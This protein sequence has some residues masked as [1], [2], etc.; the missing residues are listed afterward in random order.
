MA[1]GDAADA[2]G[3][4]VLAGTEDLRDS[5]VEHNRSRDYIATH[6]TS[7]THS[8]AAITSGTLDADRLPPIPQS[9]IPDEIPISKIGSGVNAGR[10]T[11][12]V[13]TSQVIASGDTY[14]RSLVG[15]GNP[16][17]VFVAATSGNYGGVTSALKDKQDVAV[18]EIPREVLRAWR[19]KFFRYIAAVQNLGDDAPM[20]LGGIAD[21]AHELGLTYL[22]DYDDDGEVYGLNHHMLWTIGL[23]LAQDAE[24]RIDGLLERV[25]KLEEGAA[26]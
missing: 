7:G 21:E 9:K 14:S 22:V 3:M 25:E 1:I 4:V 6:A 18:A 2:A 11:G 10:W 15:E 26:S 24:D 20:Q 13:V 5:Y 8:A 23:L 19:P 17:T 12:P 16:R